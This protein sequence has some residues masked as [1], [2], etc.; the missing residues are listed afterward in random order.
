M[1]TLIPVA[2]DYCHLKN[3]YN[4]ILQGDKIILKHKTLE[5]ENLSEKWFCYYDEY[6]KTIGLC[7][8]DPLSMIIYDKDIFWFPIESWDIYKF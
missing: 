5:Y 8:I 6:K 4:D 2:V 7:Y 1:Q 3:T